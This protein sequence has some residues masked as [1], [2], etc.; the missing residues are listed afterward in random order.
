MTDCCRTRQTES[1]A[2]NHRPHCWAR[3]V[4]CALVITGLLSIFS[5]NTVTGQETRSQRPLSSPNV[6]QRPLDQL[7]LLMQQQQLTHPQEI[8]SPRQIQDSLN[9]SDD[10]MKLLRDALRQSGILPPGISGPSDEKRPSPEEMIRQLREMKQ[11]MISAQP[12]AAGQGTSP[13]AVEGEQP[14]P[15]GLTAPPNSDRAG[16]SARPAGSGTEST[17]NPRSRQPNPQ[18]AGSPSL[19]ESPSASTNERSPF[20]RGRAER[21]GSPGSRGGATGNRTTDRREEVPPGSQGGT[22]QSSSTGGAGFDIGEEL[23]SKGLRKTVRRLVRDVQKQV[24]Q[25]ASNDDQNASSEPS[26]LSRALANVFDSVRDD[27][28]KTIRESRDS[29]AERSASRSSFRPRQDQSTTAGGRTTGTAANGNQQSTD[30]SSA[31]SSPGLISSLRDSL[32]DGEAFT[33]TGSGWQLLVILVVLGIAAVVYLLSE[34]RQSQ[35]RRSHQR[36]LRPV[37][38]DQIRTREDVIHAFHWLVHCQSPH[39]ADWWN[40]LQ[41]G[42]SVPLQSTAH[43]ES[44]QQLMRL[45]ELARYEPEDRAFEPKHVQQAR[46]ALAGCL[47]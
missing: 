40:H 24:A 44:L 14:A 37:R 26:P 28:V 46:Q 19:G 42:D 16:S 43:Q 12:N 11:N 33:P 17:R 5:V 22:R 38:P 21:R 36:R 32:P 23:S 2:D 10:Q 1:G 3:S 13:D 15:S 20:E 31:E 9:L 25:N 30:T 8:P 34:R 35:E 4:L 39:A 7:R 27:V 41:A 45:Y 18:R 29:R 47:S 6:P